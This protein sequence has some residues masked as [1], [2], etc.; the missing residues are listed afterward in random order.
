MKKEE[1]QLSDLLAVE[2][3]NLANER[4]FLAY[5]RSSV[6]FLATG[7]SILHIHLFEKVDYLGWGFII[8]SPIMFAIGLQRLITVRKVINRAVNKTKN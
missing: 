3:T 6:F 2:R 4:T 5:F 7:I 1:L 8:L